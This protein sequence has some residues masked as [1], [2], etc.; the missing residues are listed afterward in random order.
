MGGDAHDCPGNGER[1]FSIEEGS[2]IPSKKE[3]TGFNYYGGERG[4]V[5]YEKKSK[6]L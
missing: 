1:P 6:R 4:G 2:I 5:P 3:V